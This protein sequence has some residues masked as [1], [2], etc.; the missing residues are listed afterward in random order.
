MLAQVNKRIERSSNGVRK[1]KLRYTFD[2]IKHLHKIDDIIIKLKDLDA[3][4][5]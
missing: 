1:F 5:D 2:K 3:W 4:K